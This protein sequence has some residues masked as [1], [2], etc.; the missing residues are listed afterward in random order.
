MAHVPPQL[1]RL[2][3]AQRP[4]GPAH[5]HRH[6]QRSAR[7]A[8]RSSP[9]PA[10]EPALEPAVSEVSDLVRPWPVRLLRVRLIARIARMAGR[11]VLVR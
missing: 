3:G 10:R 9:E 1:A 4:A 2:A 6:P 5:P 7:R 8:Q 11:L